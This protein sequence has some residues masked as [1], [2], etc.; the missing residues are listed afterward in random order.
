[1]IGVKDG[2]EV[3]L[4]GT[5]F[6]GVRQGIVFKGSTGEANVMGV[7]AKINLASG[8]S[9][10]VIMQGKGRANATVMNMTI[11][12]DG[13]GTGVGAEMMGEGT[14]MLNMVNISRVGVG[15]RVTKGTLEVTKGSIQGTTVGAEVSGSGVLEVNGRATI[16]GTTMGLRVTGSGKATMMGGSIQG[17]GSGGSYGVIVES[18][19]NVTLS[20]VE[21]SRFKMGVYV[22][23]GTF[24]MTGGSI[25]GK[26]SG[27]SYGVYAMG[28]DVTLNM[29]NILKVQTGVRVMGGTFKMTEGSVTD[30]AGTGVMVGEEV[31]SATLMDV[32]ITGGGKGTGVYMEGK[33]VTLNMVNISQ[34]ETGVY[35][36][37]GTFKM[38]GGSVTDFT[39]TGVMVGD[40]VTKA[41]LTRVTITGQNKGTGVMMMGGD[42]TLNMVMISQVEMGVY[43]RKGVLK[44]EGGSVTEFTGTGVMVGEEVESASLTGTT[45]TGGGSGSYGVIVESSGNVTLNMVTISKVGVG[46]EVEKGTLIMNQGSVTDFTGTGVM[47]G[48]G[49]K[50]ASLMGVEI[51]GKD[52]GDSYGVYAMGGAGM[53]ISLDGVKVSRVGTGVKVERGKLIMNQGSVTDFASYG[54]IVGDGVESASLM[55][56]TITGDGKG[57]GVYAVGG[58]VTLN[59]VNILKVQT[60]VVMGRGKSLMISGGSIKEVQTGVAM[61]S[62]WLTVKDGTKIEFM[63]DYGVYMGSG[64]K[65]ASLKGTTIMGGGSGYGIHAV[66]DVTLKDVRISKVG[67]G[68]YAKKGVFKMEGGSTISFMGEYGVYMGDGVKSASLTGTVIRGGGSGQGVYAERGTNLT[69]MLENVTISGVGTGVRMMGGKSLTITG[70]SIKEVQT[71]VAMSS[72]W[73]TVKD[74]TKIEFMGEYGVYMGDGVKSASLMGTRITGGGSGQGVYAERG[75]GMAMRLEGVTISRVGTGVRV[76]GGKSLTITGGSIKEVQTG[77]AMMKGESLMISGSSTISFMGDYGVYMGDK[78]TKADLVRVM[79]E[80]NGKGTGTGIH[81]MGGNVMVSGGEIKKVQ[82]GIAMS[83][84]WLTVKDGT[85]IEFM[86][87]YGVYMGSGVKS[88]SLTGTVI[89]GNGKGKGTG[90]YAVGG[91][92]MGS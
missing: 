4:M 63:G 59:M 65:S 52:S 79:I 32:T 57:T 56:T 73:L 23:G 76:M 38:T 40:G 48:D 7:G 31:E 26:D 33:K 27:D 43:A 82:M 34:V 81:A 71:G 35:A 91:R 2:G 86:G 9:T 10:G 12:G 8:N 77:V 20:E 50:S 21:I 87:D 39:G 61:S 85:K 37:K 83:S 84:G 68:V 89:R 75:T 46:V 49:V 78:V 51:T 17:G 13:K 88:A 54:V 47:V 66:G 44:M 70:G 58:N 14:L 60:G 16:V 28:G 74:G 15:A 24:K 22:K 1:M 3:T 92:G 67:V 25:T 30:F 45:I 6:T 69:M 19:G 90:V 42:V 18:S 11:T 5:N 62:G 53:T 41:D 29:V 64:V 55:G 36:K 80:G 72:G